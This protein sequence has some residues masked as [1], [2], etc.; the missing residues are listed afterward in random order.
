[1]WGKTLGSNLGPAVQE[2]HDSYANHINQLSHPKTIA[3]TSYPPDVV[4][5]RVESAIP[6]PGPLFAT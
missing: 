3:D 6:S 2:M 1:M 4:I 5:V